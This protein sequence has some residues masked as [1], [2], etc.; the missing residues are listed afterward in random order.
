MNLR[1]DS[2]S[3]SSFSEFLGI[4]FRESHRAIMDF[5]DDRPSSPP[6]ELYLHNHIES[7]HY[8]QALVG[9]VGYL[10]ASV[11]YSVT[12]CLLNFIDNPYKPLTFSQRGK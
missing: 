3:M 10:M 11:S 1:P 12:G 5:A 6:T 2:R 7:D 8:R 9:G 4:P